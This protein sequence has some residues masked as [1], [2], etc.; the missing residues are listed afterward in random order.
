MRRVVNLSLPLLK[1]AQAGADMIRIDCYEIKEVVWR[2]SVEELC[3]NIS[4]RSDQWRWAHITAPSRHLLLAIEQDFCC[5]ICGQGWPNA[6][7]VLTPGDHLRFIFLDKTRRIASTIDHIKPLSKGGPD[8][9]A[10]MALACSTCNNYKSN[11]DGIDV[12]EILLD[13]CRHHMGKLA[14][15]PC[16]PG[17]NQE[18]AL[19]NELQDLRRKIL[20]HVGK[21]H[22]YNSDL[23]KQNRPC[24]KVPA[25]LAQ[26]FLVT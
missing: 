9:V 18:T 10:N 2:G 11:F 24:I 1:L 25:N 8:T 3:N 16:P 17:L 4:W 12:V 7:I 6:M 13:K 21:L 23:V 5:S 15:L 26:Y 19:T 22:N 14:S 20:K